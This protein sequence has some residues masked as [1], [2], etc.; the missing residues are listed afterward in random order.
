MRCE[1]C[2]SLLARQGTDPLQVQQGSQAIRGLWQVR[3]LRDARACWRSLIATGATG[4]GSPA[5]GLG[6]HHSFGDTENMQASDARGQSGC[7]GCVRGGRLGPIGD[8]KHSF[9]AA[10]QHGGRRFAV[11]AR[12]EGCMSLL[13]RHGTDPAQVEEG[14]QLKLRVAGVGLMAIVHRHRE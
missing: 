12:R 6:M 14:C 4:E 3:G 5:L 11:G 10:R 7:G 9:K 1:G 13:A 8:A 2:I